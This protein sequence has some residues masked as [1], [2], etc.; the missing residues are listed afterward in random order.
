MDRFLTGIENYLLLGL[1]HLVGNRQLNKK[2]ARVCKWQSFGKNVFNL[3]HAAF[4]HHFP[5]IILLKRHDEFKN[6][7]SFNICNEL[8]CWFGKNLL[9]TL[10]LKMYYPI[11]LK[12]FLEFT[13][14]SS[15]VFYIW[16]IFDY[17]LC[18]CGLTTRKQNF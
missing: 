13:Y 11:T 14:K 3:Q 7:E 15:H 1:G 2:L 6:E 8:V 16:P 10:D 12:L 5:F 18:D 4:Q 9:N 17:N